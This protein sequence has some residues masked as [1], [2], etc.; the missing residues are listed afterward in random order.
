MPWFFATFSAGDIVNVTGTTRHLD[1][2]NGLG[3]WVLSWDQWQQ[4]SA[5]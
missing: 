4:G 5:L 2:H 1:P 3:D